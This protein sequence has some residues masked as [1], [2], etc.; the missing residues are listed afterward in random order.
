MLVST[1]ILLFFLLLTYAVFLISTRKSEARSARLQQR[2]AEVLQES[3]TLSTDDAVQI[4][5]E[6]SISR[7]A[8]LNRLLS[9]VGFI[10]QLDS[11][12]GQADMHITVS[13]LL[14]FCVAAAL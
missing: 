13:R 14:A 12:I 10:K 2:V 8:T 1:S 5:R 9:S 7:N 4:L 6:D 11:T 3:W